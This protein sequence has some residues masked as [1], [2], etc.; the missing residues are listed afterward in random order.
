MTLSFIGALM[1]YKWLTILFNKIKEITGIS[2]MRT[3][4]YIVFF[5]LETKKLKI[6]Y[7]KLEFGVL[8]V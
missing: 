8:M 4:V 3:V 5:K 7:S 6:N 2:E 1:G